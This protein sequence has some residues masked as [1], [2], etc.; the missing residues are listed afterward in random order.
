M[1]DRRGATVFV[2][3]ASGAVGSVLC[4]LLIDDGWK[5]VGT[6]RS[7]DKADRLRELGV[8]PVVVNVFDADALK[9]AVAAASPVAVIHQLTDLP[10]ELTRDSLATA[11]PKNA[12][13]REVG[14]ANLVAA[15]VH[16]GARRL[17]AQSIAFAYAA[18]ARPLRET[19]PLDGAATAVMKL[20]ELVRNAPLEGIVLRYGHFYGPNTWSATATGESPVHIEAAADAA[21]RALTRGSPGV[22]NVAEDDGVISSEKARRELGWSPAFRISPGA[23]R[24]LP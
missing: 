15:S 13:M 23:G 16:A 6:T 3:G 22:Y 11:R 19:A 7:Q 20:E 4:R 12:Q 5:V 21:R 18:G 9:A 8:T 17:V 24:R 10:K 1:T 14:T 2:A